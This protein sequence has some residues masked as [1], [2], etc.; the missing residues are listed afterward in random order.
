VLAEE[1]ARLKVLMKQWFLIFS[2]VT[3]YTAFASPADLSCASGWNNEVRVIP[4]DWIND[5]YCDC[6]LDGKDEPDTEACSGSNS[7][8]GLSTDTIEE[9]RWDQ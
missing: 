4:A 1:K 9:T 3:S 6:P 7:W 5:G 8:P 2:L